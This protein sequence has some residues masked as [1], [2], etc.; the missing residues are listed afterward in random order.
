VVGVKFTQLRL[1]VVVE[2]AN[3]KERMEWRH[4][5]DNPAI[6]K[7]VASLVRIDVVLV[8]VIIMYPTVKRV[9]LAI[10]VKVAGVKFTVLR[11]WV[12]V[13]RVKRKLKMEWRHGAELT[14]IGK[15]VA[16]LVRIDVVLVGVIGMYQTVNRVGFLIIVK[17]DGV[18]F[19]RL[20]RLLALERAN[21]KE[22]MG[23]RHGTALTAI[24][25]KVVSPVTID[26]ALAYQVIGKYLMVTD[27]GLVVIVQVVGVKEAVGMRRNVMHIANPKKMMDIGLM[28]D[29]IAAVTLVGSNAVLAYQGTAKSPMVTR[30][31]GMPTVKVITVAVV[32]FVVQLAYDSKNCL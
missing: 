28:K 24:G 8:G 13:E 22:G 10:I 19:M 29:G 17:V 4:G 11:W 32:I 3:R 20:S 1:S 21:E 16:S 12:A 30:A 25:K 18:K 23:K 31:S 14:A 27:V 7:E 15:K 5:A 2:H 26:V 9:G 6:G